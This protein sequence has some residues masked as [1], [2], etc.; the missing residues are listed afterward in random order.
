[1]VLLVTAGVAA[2]KGGIAVKQHI[3]TRK[4]PKLDGDFITAPLST[5]DGVSQRHKASLKHLRGSLTKIVAQSVKRV[6]SKSVTHPSSVAEPCPCKTQ[7]AVVHYELGQEVRLKHMADPRLNDRTA[8]V[9]QHFGAKGVL[10]Q[11]MSLESKQQQQQQQQ[12]QHEQDED[13]NDGHYFETG[14]HVLPE[15]L[16]PIE[17]SP[18]IDDNSSTTD[19][20]KDQTHPMLGAT[21]ELQHLSAASQKNGLRGMI[22]VPPKNMVLGEGRVAV[23]VFDSNGTISIGT[24]DGKNLIS[25]KPEN[26]KV[27]DDYIW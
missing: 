20:Q 1:M 18:A 10:V 19:T 8:L 15:N 9:M 4:N 16:E 23:K 27:V 26:C 12:H 13:E 7:E 3:E 11:F 2:V 25:V 17:A 5:K 14:M 24:E 6:S 21:I 22:V